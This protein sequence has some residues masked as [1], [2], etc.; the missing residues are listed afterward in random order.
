MKNC[1]TK[2]TRNI[3]IEGGVAKK[4][5]KV[6]DLHWDE[7][8]TGVVGWEKKWMRYSRPGEEIVTK[9][10]ENLNAQRRLG[11]K[12]ALTEDRRNKIPKRGFS[13]R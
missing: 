6:G 12:R 2:G 1:V 10:M 3:L 7:S 4:N 13:P 5:W 11:E 8:P 9:V